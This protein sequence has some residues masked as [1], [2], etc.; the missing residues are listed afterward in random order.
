MCGALRLADSDVAAPF[1]QAYDAQI[2]TVSVRRTPTD[3]C[4]WAPAKGLS[5][6]PLG[7]TTPHRSWEQCAVAAV[8]GGR[9]DSVDGFCLVSVD[10]FYRTHPTLHPVHRH[11]IT[12]VHTILPLQSRSAI[13]RTV[14][15]ACQPATGFPVW[16]PTGKA[17]KPTHRWGCCHQGD[18]LSL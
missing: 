6:S 2:P 15:L 1:V 18:G 16:S 14:T 7:R 17:I 4:L 8:R 5:Y 9:S 12:P 3:H 10:G 13:S 11:S